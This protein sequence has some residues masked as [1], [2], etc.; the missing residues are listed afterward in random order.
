MLNNNFQKQILEK[1][2]Y[3]CVFYHSK[4]LAFLR[5]QIYWLIDDITNVPT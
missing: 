3:K 4:H 1:L 5:K 2:I